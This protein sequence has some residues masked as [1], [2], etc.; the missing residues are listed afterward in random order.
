M[1]RPAL[2]ALGGLPPFL[3]HQNHY[4]PWSADPITA[5][6]LHVVETKHTYIKY[7]R[8]SVCEGTCRTGASSRG[9]TNLQP[10]GV[11]VQ[12]TLWTPGRYKRN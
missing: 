9:G 4:H 10:I 3:W 12:V 7:A 1:A 11:N 2:V 6:R 5:S 8:A